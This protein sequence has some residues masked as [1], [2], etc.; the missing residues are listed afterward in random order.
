MDRS[1]CGFLSVI[2]YHDIKDVA[3]FRK[4]RVDNN[5]NDISQRTW[6]NHRKERSREISHITRY[7]NDGGGGER[8]RFLSHFSHIQ[9]DKLYE[10]EKTNHKLLKCLECLQRHKDYY[11]LR[12]ANKQ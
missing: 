11:L 4:F 12:K 3:A 7:A 2:Y 1:L 10:N 8:E 5:R 9:F 6:A